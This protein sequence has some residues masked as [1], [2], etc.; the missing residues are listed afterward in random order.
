MK[1]IRDKMVNRSERRRGQFLVGRKVMNSSVRSFVI[2]VR[3]LLA[4]ALGILLIVPTIVAA[5]TQPSLLTSRAELTAAAERAE[6]NQSGN[7]SDALAA[8][9]IKQRL[10]EGDFNPGDRI[11]LRV[12][13]DQLRT[14]TLLVR[15]GR[16]I[17]LP[18][19]TTVSLDGVLRSEVSDKVTAQVLRYVKARQV[20]VVPLTRIAVLGEVARPGYFALPS[21]VAI[22]EAIMQAGGPTGTAD[23]DRSTVLRGQQHI[24]SGKD[25]IAAL[26]NG[27]TLDQ[28]GLTAGDQIVVGR[29]RDLLNGSLMPFVGAIASL[30]AIFVALHH[31]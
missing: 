21:D 6:K 11:I 5:Q 30:A 29:S 2:R 10:R 1:V 18:G 15:S 14:D 13:T 3:G 12:F 16:L 4:A 27:Q 20:E 19:K 26:S 31:R 8:A 23:M 25:L 28:F 22:G 7:T 9:A 17:D 24:R